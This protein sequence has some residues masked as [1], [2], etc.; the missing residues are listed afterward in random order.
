M[1]VETEHVP[2]GVDI[3]LNR[4]GLV[5]IC[6]PRLSAVMAQAWHDQA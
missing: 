4:P 2:L 3:D 6:G 1:A 5:V